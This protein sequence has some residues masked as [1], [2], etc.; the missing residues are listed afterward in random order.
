MASSKGTAASDLS[1]EGHD[2]SC[3][4]DRPQRMEA[5]TVWGAAPFHGHLPSAYI[6]FQGVMVSGLMFK[7]W[8]H[9]EFLLLCDAILHVSVQFSPHHSLER[10]SLSHSISLSPLSQTS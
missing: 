7:S 10:R 2:G 8:I 5:G 4:E 9:V 3:T 6:F 1:L